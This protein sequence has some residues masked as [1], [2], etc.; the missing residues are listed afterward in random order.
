MTASQRPQP[1]QRTRSPSVFDA[2]GYRSRPYASSGRLTKLLVNAAVVFHFGLLV[3]LWQEAKFVPSIAWTGTSACLMGM[4]ALAARHGSLAVRNATVVAM[5]FF[6]SYPVFGWLSYKVWGHYSS[7]R[8]ALLMQVIPI[9]FLGFMLYLVGAAARS[10]RAFPALWVVWVIITAYV[11][12]NAKKFDPQAMY[13]QKQADGGSAFNYQQM[14]DAFAICCAILAP[15]I[16]KVVNQWIFVLISVGVMFII[17]SR[18]AALFGAASLCLTFILFGNRFTRISLLSVIGLAGFGYIT[19]AFVPL[20]EGTRFE[21]VFSPDASDSSWGSRQEIMDY[22]TA[23][24]ISK[25]FTGEWAFQLSDLKFSG[26]YIHNALDIWAQTGLVP[27]LLFLGIWLFLFDAMITGL[28][29]WPRVTKEVMPVLTFVAMSWVLS[30]NVTFV[31]L[32]FGVGFAS[33]SLAMAR[34][35]DPARRRRRDG[36]GHTQMGGATRFSPSQFANTQF[37]DTQFRH[38]QFGNT[39]FGNTQA[40]PAT[41]EELGLPTRFEDELPQTQIAQPTIITPASAGHPAANQ[42]LHV[43]TSNPDGLP[44]FNGTLNGVSPLIAGVQMET[45]VLKKKAATPKHTMAPHRNKVAR[46]KEEL[47]VREIGPRE[48]LTTLDDVPDEFAPRRHWEKPPELEDSS[49][50][51][52]TPPRQTGSPSDDTVPPAD[53]PNN[54]P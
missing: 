24:L 1:S 40:A 15:R 8:E 38:S 6:L 20:F 2:L 39:K 31:A 42:V 27:F 33:A 25:P 35:G 17:P 53:T 23:L 10:H 4:A 13:E 5:F 41:P 48:R 43:D 29:R 9:M 14:G 47:K 34:F 45:S 44:Q 32:F 12:I 19:G 50:R 46:K 36:F 30:R 18:S 52:P 51:Q 49:S 21:S 16:R 11:L 3:I 22:G 37:S 26:Y 7:E 54:K 28:V